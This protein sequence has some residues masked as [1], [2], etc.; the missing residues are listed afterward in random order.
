MVDAVKSRAEV[1]VDAYLDNH[2]ERHSPDVLPPCSNIPEV[3]F[4]IVHDVR[5]HQRA[6]NTAHRELTPP[7]VPD[8]RTLVYSV[9]SVAQ[10]ALLRVPL[11]LVATQ[12]SVPHVHTRPR[13]YTVMDPW[14]VP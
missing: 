4:R 7:G 11:E 3:A 5:R 8:S 13:T 2:D 6:L 12:R 1:V 9:A 10:E 14:S